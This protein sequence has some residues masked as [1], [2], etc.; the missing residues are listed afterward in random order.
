MARKSQ[1][2]RRA[3]Q[4]EMSHGAAAGQLRKRI[5]FDLLQR[6]G[7]DTCYRCSKTIETVDELSI[8]HKVPWFNSDNPKELFFDLGN[9]AFAH[10]KCN[11]SNSR[12]PARIID[13]E[14]QGWCSRCGQFKLLSE[15]P[16]KYLS[17]D[18]RKRRVCTKCRTEVG[19]EQRKKHRKSIS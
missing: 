4:L 12:R 10:L 5:M 19:R 14:G 1:S 2:K 16:S 11:I 8:D 7:L 9:I 13:P 17:P 6:T 3:K 18:G 15:F